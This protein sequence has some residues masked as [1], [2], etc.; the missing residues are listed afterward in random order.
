MPSGKP[1]MLEIKVTFA[2]PQFA[3]SFTWKG[4]EAEADAA[5]VQMRELAQK[6]NA[7]P[8]TF[9]RNELV[10]ASTM[11]ADPNPLIR[12]HGLNVALAFV[13]E[14]ETRH[15]E[16]PGKFRDYLAVYD[17]EF[18][19]THMTEHSVTVEVE[20]TAREHNVGVVA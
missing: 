8:I 10:G 13:L 3:S 5:V 18:I 7:D 1:N 6:V 17:F 11:L 16:Y 2:L 19:I 9:L 4:N 15:P 20:A 14:A 12:R